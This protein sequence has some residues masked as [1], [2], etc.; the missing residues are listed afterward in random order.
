MAPH[1]GTCARR[2][3]WSQCPGAERRRIDPGWRRGDRTSDRRRCDSIASRRTVAGLGSRGARQRHRGQ[4]NLS[5]ASKINLLQRQRRSPRPRPRQ[6]KVGPFN[7]SASLPGRSTSIQNFGAWAID[8]HDSSSPAAAILDPCRR[9]SRTGLQSSRLGLAC[10]GVCE[11]IGVLR[12]GL[13]LALAVVDP[14][15]PEAVDR[16]ILGGQAS[17][18]CAG[19]GD[20]SS[21][22]TIT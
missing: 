4:I 20:T 11:R 7:R 10:R 6:Q 15:R 12:I 17:L 9:N 19:R 22:A 16:H 8:P 1:S 14:D 18:A 3:S 5:P 21:N 13:E 2:I